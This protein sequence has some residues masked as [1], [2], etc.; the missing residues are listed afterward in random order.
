MPMLC[1]PSYGGRGL[2]LESIMR[3]RH[4]QSRPSYGGRGL[5]PEMKEQEELKDAVAPRMGGVD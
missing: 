2:K 3:L 4:W 1:R 5:K